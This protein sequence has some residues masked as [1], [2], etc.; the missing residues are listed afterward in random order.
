MNNKIGIQLDNRQIGYKFE[1]FSNDT[2]LEILKK[3]SRI[4][5]KKCFAYFTIKKKLLL[6][7]FVK[8]LRVLALKILKAI[9][10]VPHKLRIYAIYRCVT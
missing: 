6:L 10:L 4:Y 8:I 7:L 5:F 2:T 9:F 3:S 1:N